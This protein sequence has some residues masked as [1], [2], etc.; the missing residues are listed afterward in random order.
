[1]SVLTYRNGPPQLV[2]VPSDPA[3]AI[4]PGMLLG[5]YSGAVRPPSSL[6][7]LGSLEGTQGVFAEAFLGVAHSSSEIGE[8]ALISVDL[9]PMSVYAPALEPGGCDFGDPLAPADDGDVLSDTRLAPVNGRDLAVAMAMET[10][11]ADAPVARVSFA[12]AYCPAANH[13]LAFGPT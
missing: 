7:W 8:S 3:F 11:A 13:T 6:T 9:S 5:L 2:Q 12:S 10:V 4:R 1:M